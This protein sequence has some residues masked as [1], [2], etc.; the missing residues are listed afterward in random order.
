MKN[1]LTKKW[2]GP[3]FL[4][5]YTLGVSFSLIHKMVPYMKEMFPVINQEAETFLPITFQNGEIVQPQNTIISKNYTDEKG[6]NFSVIL[7]TRTDM[8]DLNKLPKDGFFISK[9]CVYIVSPDESRVKCFDS[10][11]SQE[12]FVITKEKL[13]NWLNKASKY[14]TTFLT[15]FFAITLFIVFY[16]IILFYT[17]IMHWIVALLS[18]T[19][20]GQTLFINTL[21]YIGW[22]LV[23]AITPIRIG[24]LLKVVL[25]ICI[26]W[27][28]CKSINEKKEN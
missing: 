7:D 3:L 18:K 10:I 24:F 5:L 17:I 11:Q 21:T 1:F 12:P 8:L 13:E 23:E 27:I 26:N 6:N 25:F 16:I 9:K 20:F 22:N 15:A 2:L 28:V 14:A 19:S 4:F